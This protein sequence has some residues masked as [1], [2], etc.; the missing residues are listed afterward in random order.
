MCVYR[1]RVL[2]IDE[3]A[4]PQ[5]ENNGRVP[6]SGAPVVLTPLACTCKCAE[7]RGGTSPWNPPPPRSY[8]TETDIT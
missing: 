5:A 2:R 7:L 6:A 1:A 3:V 8:A 4:S